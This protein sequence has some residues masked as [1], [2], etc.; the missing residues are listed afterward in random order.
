MAAMIVPTGLCSAQQFNATLVLLL[1]SVCFESQSIIVL[2]CQCV[3]TAQVLVFLLVLVY[4]ASPS[5]GVF[6]GDS[7]L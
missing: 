7:V 1:V 5:L 6:A 4:C 3:L 2:A